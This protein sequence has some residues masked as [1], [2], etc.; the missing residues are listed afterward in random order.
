M[1]DRSSADRAYELVNGFRASQLVRLACELR[2]PDRV[3][4][5]PLSAEELSRA[6]G[7]NAVRLR[8]ALR[9][10]AAL[11]VLQETEDGYFRNT[12]VGELFRD[13]IDGSQRAR[14][15]MLIPES[16]RAWDHLIE[17]MRTGTTGHEIAHGGTLWDSLARDA[18]FAARF[19]QAMASGSQQVAQFVA[20]G[21][22]FSTVS[23]IVDVGGGKGALAAGILRTH[24]HLRG[25]I[26]DL[27]AGLAETQQYL[28]QQGVSERCDVVESNFF[29]EVPK[30]GDVYLL[31]DIIHDWDDHHASQI[32]RSCRRACHSGAQILLIERVLPAQVTESPEHLNATMTDLQMMVQLGSRERTLAEYRVLLEQA[33]FHAGSW[34]PGPLYGIVEGIA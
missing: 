27:A 25:V 13:G 7:I 6:T 14:A 20:S 30:G 1:V 32:L 12:D 18:D 10:L 26:S 4:N 29:D 34:V 24:G 17:T 9:G 16:Y 23:L 15:M 28:A 5:G 31:K 3:A 8:R 21:W 2:V 22:E 11:G 33:G 19:N